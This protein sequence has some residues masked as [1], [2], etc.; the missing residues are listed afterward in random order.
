MRRFALAL[1]AAFAI[2]SPAS[3]QELLAPDEGD[4]Y[5]DLLRD[6]FAEA[7]GGDAVLS[8]TIMPN[9]ANEQAVVLLRTR[10][11][12]YS[13][14]VLEPRVHL[15]RYQLAAMMENGAVRN[16][17]DPSGETTRKD[18]RELLKGLPDDPTTVPLDRCQRSLPERT[19]ALIAMAWRAMLE[20]TG[21]DEDPQIYLDATTY[22]FSLR[23]VEGEEQRGWVYGGR[24]RVKKLIDLA[25]G[26]ADYCKGG[27]ASDELR[28]L[29]SNVAY[30]EVPVPLP[31][32]SD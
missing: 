7:H 32:S 3:P 21:I 5:R 22:A 17:D 12:G 8:A 28:S 30:T 10:K 2:A 14:L 24:G 20:K 1:L 15:W 18:I 25:H 6:V 29:A 19:G 31:A 26:M 23:T 27:T 4:P 11:Q 9:S 16:L 13:V